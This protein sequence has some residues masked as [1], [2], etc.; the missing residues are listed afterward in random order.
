MGGAPFDFEKKF[1][2]VVLKAIKRSFLPMKARAI[3]KPTFNHRGLKK[4]LFS[5]LDKKKG[6][7]PCWINTKGYELFNFYDVLRNS[8]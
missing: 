6:F 7:F 1:Q 5:L 3:F 8:L 4:R 2:R